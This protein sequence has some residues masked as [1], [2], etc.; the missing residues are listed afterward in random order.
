MIFH[1]K[2][3]QGPPNDFNYGYSHAKRLIDVQ[4]HAYH[5]KYGCKF[6]SVIPTNVYGPHD[7]Y[8]LDV[9]EKR[10]S[11]ILENKVIY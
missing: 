8:N 7:N 6:T 1:Q 4:N 11:R 10:D 3:H 2:V 9:S 5:E